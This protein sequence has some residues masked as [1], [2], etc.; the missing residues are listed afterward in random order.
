MRTSIRLFSAAVLLTA[1]G[2]GDDEKSAS[3]SPPAGGYSGPAYGQGGAYGGYGGGG[4]GQIQFNDNAPSN[5]AA[6]KTAQE[7]VPLGEI[8][9]TDLNGQLKQLKELAGQKNVVVVLV[10][11]LQAAG[12]PLCPYCA[13]QTSRLITNYQEFKDRDAEVVVVYPLATGRDKSELT[14]FLT[15]AKQQ[16][17][18]PGAETPFP[19]WLDVDLAAVTQ[20]GLQAQL[21]KPSTYILD[22]Q[23]RVRYAYVG[24]HMADRPSI[25]ALLAQLDVLK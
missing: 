6:A 18:Q 9:F 21:A 5:D 20:L 4:D 15:N 12:A 8:A 3:T 25:K 23:G 16:L 11:G 7:A 17:Q 1:V 14:S 24:S 22:K 2:C 10:R 19:V 13:T